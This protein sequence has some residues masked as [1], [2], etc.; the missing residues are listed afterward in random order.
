[1]LNVHK[2]VNEVLPVS[3][4]WQQHQQPQQYQGNEN[5]EMKSNRIVRCNCVCFCAYVGGAARLGDIEAHFN[6]CVKGPLSD[7]NRR[8]R[9]LK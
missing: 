1:M 3:L 2:E 9:N 7:F 5:D 6:L 4:P 8:K